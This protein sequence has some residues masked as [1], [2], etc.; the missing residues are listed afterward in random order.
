MNPPP[1]N[2]IIED[3]NKK[4]YGNHIFVRKQLTF[5]LRANFK[6]NLHIL[7]GGS[8]IS[9][10]GLPTLKRCANLFY[11]CKIYAGNRMKMKEFGPKEG[12]VS[13]APLL[14]PPLILVVFQYEEKTL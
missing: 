7:T 4:N 6:V 5:F 14:D 9:Q 8:R 12:R 3:K 1:N 13:L 2:F 11:F 10:R